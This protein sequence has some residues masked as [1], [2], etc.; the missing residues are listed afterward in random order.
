M[1]TC[2]AS[3][4]AKKILTSVRAK[5]RAFDAFIERLNPA[6]KK[7]ACGIVR[8][9]QRDVSLLHARKTEIFD[10]KIKRVC[11]EK[12]QDK[13]ALCH[14]QKERKRITRRRRRNRNEPSN[15]INT[16]DRCTGI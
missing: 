14:G 16:I 10:T 15:G 2:L 7:S 9:K 1:K 13:F 4:I 3:L 12:F 6:R 11:G 5:L 8:F